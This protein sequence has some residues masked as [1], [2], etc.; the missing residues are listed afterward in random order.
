M[1]IKDTMELGGVIRQKRKSQNLTQSEL[2]AAAGVG[3]R[4]IV[5]LEKGKA[6]CQLGK[7]LCVINMVGMVLN[8]EEK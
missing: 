3:V 2:A 8:L 4:L 7:A 1:I 6:T 5:D